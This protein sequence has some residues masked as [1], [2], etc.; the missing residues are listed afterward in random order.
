MML[1]IED[2]L[3]GHATAAMY[4]AETPPPAADFHRHT[5]ITTVRGPLPCLA[6]QAT[7][8]NLDHL[9]GRIGRYQGNINF[10]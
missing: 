10:K 5:Y 4:I 1:E 2:Y 8:R 7:K 9:S 3:F 6:L